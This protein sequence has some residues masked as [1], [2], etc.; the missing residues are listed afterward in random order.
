MNVNARSNDHHHTTVQESAAPRERRGGV[1]MNILVTGASGLIGSALVPFLTAGGHRVTRLVRSHPRPGEMAVRWDPAAGALETTALEGSDAVVHLAGENIAE[2]WSAEKK[3]RIRD[4]RVRGTRLLSEA[5]VQLA[6][7]PKVLV[8]ASAIGYYGNRGEEILT[9]E[10]A[11]GSGFLAEVCRAWEAA[12]EGALQ[13][14]MRVVHLRFG[15]VLSPAGGALGKMLPA[16]RMGV[17]GMLGSGRQY[18]SWIALD[19]AVGALHHALMTETL[20]GPANAVAP[21]AVM[22]QEFTKTLGRVLGRPT[23]IPLPAFAARLMFGEMADELLLAS[24]RVRP[25]KLQT[26]GYDYRY[27]ELEAA[28]RH[29][30]GA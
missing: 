5:L 9:E 24:T 2:R 13:K 15:L 10:S 3:T 27:P 4:S 16:F 22:N 28:L 26:T 21:N 7:P 8:S 11:P 17:G 30:L 1:S 19:D 20:R 14:G 6:T 23:M 12:T 29:L 25:A 18:V